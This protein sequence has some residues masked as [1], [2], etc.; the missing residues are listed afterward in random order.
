MI[1]GRRSL[2]ADSELC[3]RLGMSKPAVVEAVA[4]LMLILKDPPAQPVILGSAAVVA[5][6]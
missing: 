5:P 3:T 1:G 4:S 2:F 6:S